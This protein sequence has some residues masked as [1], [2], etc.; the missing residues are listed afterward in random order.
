MDKVVVLTG[1]S[2][3]LGS[4]FIKRHAGSCQIVAVCNR[5]GLDYTS[6]NQRYVDPL[7]IKETTFSENENPVWAVQTDLTRPDAITKLCETVINRYGRIDLLVNNACATRYWRKLLISSPTVALGDAEHTFAVNVIAP[8]RLSLGFAAAF[9]T[10]REPEENF[11][12]GRNIVN[13]SSTAGS[14]VYPDAGQT[15]Y[16]ASKAAL[17]FASY[18]LSS[19]LWAIGVRVNTVAPNSFPGIV[20][21]DRVLDTIDQVDHGRETGKIVMVDRLTSKYSGN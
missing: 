4:A 3:V 20:S 18:H 13:L 8:L 10:R 7:D 19:E 2:G 16:S 1:A 5:R 14:Y 21:I 11:E 15:I 12:A 17:N 9:W 6:Q